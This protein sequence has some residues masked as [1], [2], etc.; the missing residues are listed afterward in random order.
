MFRRHCVPGAVLLASL[1]L[2]PAL[3]TRG[4][5]TYPLSW[6]FSGPP[7][8]NPLM[9]AYMDD[10]RSCDP[11]PDF[12][13][14]DGVDFYADAGIEILAVNDGCR[15]LSRPTRPGSRGH[16]RACLAWFLP[17]NSPTGCH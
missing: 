4:H 12:W 11:N 7:S 1:M 9:S 8:T 10:H 15:L 5:E 16:D 3:S 13:F 14:H 2:L 6:P 17:I